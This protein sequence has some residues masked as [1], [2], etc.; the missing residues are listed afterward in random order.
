LKHLTACILLLS[1]LLKNLLLLLCYLI[2]LSY[3]L[4]YSFLVLCAT[5]FNYNMPWRV[6]V[7]VM[8]VWCSGGLYMNGQLLLCIWEMFWIYFAQYIAYIFACI[9]PHSLCAWFA[10]LFFSW[11]TEFLHIPFTTLESFV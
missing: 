11:I 1:F 3:N 9:S 6:S 5:C 4:Q 8:S 7:L 2:F 10:A